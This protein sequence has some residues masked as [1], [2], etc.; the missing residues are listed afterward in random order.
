MMQKKINWG[1]IGL[2]HIAHKFAEDLQLSNTAKL[3][4]V[5]SRS[6]EKANDFAKLF[7]ADYSYDSYTALAENP[8]VDAVYIATPH[9]FHFENTMLCLKNNKAVLCEKPL[10]MNAFEVK[11]MIEEAKSRKLFLMEGLW[12]R[13]IPATEKL[14]TLLNQNVIGKPFYVKADFGF[15]A[16]K[17]MNNRLFNKTLGGG[18]LLDVGIYPILLSLLTLGKPHSLKAIAKISNTGVDELCNILFKYK[19]GAIANL[20]SSLIAHSPIEG[21]IYGTQGKI[22]LHS[23][24]H[25]SKKITIWKKDKKNTFKINYLGNGYIH[26]IKEV[27]QCLLEQKTQ[28]PKLPLNLSLKLIK[29]I[30][31][32]RE[33][34]HLDYN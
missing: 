15:I 14:L 32:V 12:T 6:T 7:H 26:E 17:N 11:K 20:E 30:D 23:R 9:V 34:I 1:I 10:G 28:S 31:K 22:K 21:I 29:I 5:A 8:E 27:N 33:Q 4:A 3:Y 2:G 16:E 19:D 25:H 13:F 18:S 24:F